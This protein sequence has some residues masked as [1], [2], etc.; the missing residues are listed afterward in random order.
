VKIISLI[1]LLGIT[2]LSKD[3]H[4]PLASYEVSGGTTELLV[5]EQKL[6]VAT[7]MG[8]ID[9]FDL[10]NQ[11]KLE[12]ICVENILDF[13]GDPIESKIYSVDVLDDQILILSQ[14]EG[15]Y[16]RLHLYK[17]G[18]LQEI[19]SKDRMLSIA[20]A[21][22]LDKQRVLLALLGS[23]LLLYDMQK[24]ENIYSVQISQSKFS[25]FVL[26]EQK[27]RIVIADESG[28][29]KIHDTKS[30][31]LLDVLKGQNLDNVFKL[32]MKN[33]SIIT[34]GQDRRVVVYDLKRSSSYYLSSSFLV[35]C[36]ALSPSATLGA[37]SSD[38]HNNVSVFHTDTRS[39]LGV[40]GGSKMTLS[41]ILFLDE[42]HFFVGS[43]DKKVNFYKIP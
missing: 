27:E 38:E 37:Y 1:I 13:M 25:D 12:S 39:I 28:A 15:G 9:I 24:K 32:D 6:Y 18:V 16:R 22:F 3:I 40:F 14:A 26:D 21:K 42:K 23:E 19:L 10:Q 2:L 33:N 8:C 29:L 30:G 11:K 4:A 43:D 5:K 20:K 7:S 31:K 36:A 35:Y 34:A 41:T 17:D